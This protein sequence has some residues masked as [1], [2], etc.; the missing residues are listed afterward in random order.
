MSSDWRSVWIDVDR[1]Y[2]QSKDAPGAIIE[3]FERYAELDPA[4]RAEANEAIFEALREGDEGKRWDA[5]AMI[6]EFT[7]KEAIPDLRALSARLQVD[8]SPRAPFEVAKIDRLLKKL[9]AAS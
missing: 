4:G 2:R 9:Q 1:R 7:L 5:L 3:L 8:D 6:N